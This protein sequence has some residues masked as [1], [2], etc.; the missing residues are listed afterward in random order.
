MGRSG[1]LALLCLVAMLAA[2]V[3]GCTSSEPVP[4]STSSSWNDKVDGYVALVPQVLR[5]GESASFSFTLF[6]GDDPARSG[7]T[8]AVLDKGKTIASAT[9][10]IDG[11]GVVTVD[12]PPVA[13][14]E[15]KV[16]VSGNGF[17]K[18]TPVQIQSGTLLFL[19]TDKPIYKPGPS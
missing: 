3:V 11:K 17:A 5:S 18:S 7:V 14:G 2:I 9:G 6:K 12:L 4:T 8:V 15:Y 10:G 16:E 13:P 19:E 1:V